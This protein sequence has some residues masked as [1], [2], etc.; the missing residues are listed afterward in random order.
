MAGLV[1]R[2][3]TASGKYSKRAGFG[4]MLIWMCGTCDIFLVRVEMF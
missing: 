2:T 4:D 3:N 1:G